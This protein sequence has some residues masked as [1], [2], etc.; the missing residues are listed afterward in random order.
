MSSCH[1]TV[2][3]VDSLRINNDKAKPTERWGR[4]ATGPRFLRD[5]SNDAT[6]DPKIAEP[7]KTSQSNRWQ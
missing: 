5:A 2:I 3:G 7:P 4:K 1:P 6:K